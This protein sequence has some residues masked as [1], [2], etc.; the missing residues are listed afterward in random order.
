MNAVGD[1]WQMINRF[2]GSKPEL[3]DQFEDDLQ[4]QNG[5]L[6]TNYRSAGGIVDFCNALMTSNG[7]TGELALPFK[8]NINKKSSIVKLNV[9]S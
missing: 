4:T 5:L 6:K 7:I 8:G 2:A 9:M 1:D 3:F